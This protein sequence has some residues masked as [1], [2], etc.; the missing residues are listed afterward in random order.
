MNF[1][2]A[3]NPLVV[4]K[5]QYLLKW[6]ILFLVALTQVVS[7]SA[8]TSKAS[9]KK[10]DPVKIGHYL[11]GRYAQSIH[12]SE[13]AIKYY[14]SSLFNNPNNINLINR[15]FSVLV[16]SGRI[17]ESL[18]L[19]DNLYNLKDANSFLP[20]VVLSLKDIRA[21]NFDQAGKKL[22]SIS[23]SGITEFSMPLIGAWSFASKK[24]FSRAI[25]VLQNKMNNPGMIALFAPHAGLIA[26]LAGKSEISKYHFNEA[27]KQYSRISAN[28]TRLAGEFYERNNMSL[29][30]KVL[31]L[32][33]SKS[34]MK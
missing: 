29:K 32:N 31:Y 7:V 20:A 2:Y 4:T 8:A 34:N 22:S 27:L 23:E 28:M 24:E 5:Y 10:K 1:L 21:G 26:E 11:A 19:A 12:D 25:G 33:Y 14:R 16:F 13:A 30:A 18:P 3:L 15:T 6:T 17:K 9:Q